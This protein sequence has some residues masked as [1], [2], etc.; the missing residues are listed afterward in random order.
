MTET[1]KTKAEMLEELEA[2][3]ARVTELERS[4]A[5]LKQ[6]ERDLRAELKRKETD[7]EIE[8]KQTETQFETKL[9]ETETE[10]LYDATYELSSGVY[11]HAHLLDHL[12]I[13]VRSAQH[14]DWPLSV[15]LCRLEGIDSVEQKK[16]SEAAEEI[17]VGFGGLVRDKLRVDDFAGRY[18]EKNE[19]C[20]VFPHTSAA[21]AAAAAG[22]IR[23]EFEEQVRELPI[24]TNFGI[25]ELTS[26]DMRSVDV[27]GFADQALRQAEEGGRHVAIHTP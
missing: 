22:R 25:A 10:L 4:D 16:G 21:G 24:T 3:R 13:A 14:H 12:Q 9:E 20:I 2:L 17:L 11:S 5:K 7:F 26:R 15:C 19:L 23:E 18:A 1:E 27:L 6:T 8:L